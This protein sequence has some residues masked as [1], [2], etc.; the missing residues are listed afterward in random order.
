MPKVECPHCSAKIDAPAECAG[1]KANCAK[2][3]NSFVVNFNRPDEL[4]EFLEVVDAPPD[5][6]PPPI[7]PKAT[8]RPSI[9]DTFEPIRG[10]RHPWLE[11][12]LIF[13]K[14]GGVLIAIVLAIGAFVC[15]V[16]GFLMCLETV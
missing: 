1:R 6:F 2:C 10:K 8:Q 4:A 16:G 5:T 12:L 14:I 9:L 11:A 7:P 15:V 3:G 13:W